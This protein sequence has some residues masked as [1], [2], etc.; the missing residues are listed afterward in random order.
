MD[1]GS[2]P[3]SLARAGACA[4]LAL[5]AF[6]ARPPA[7]QAPAVDPFAPG[8]R[9]QHASSAAAPWIPRDLAFAGSGELL[10]AAP[11]VAHPHLVLLSGAP[12]GGAAVLHADDSLASALGPLRVAAGLGAERVYALAQLPDP[13][14]AQRRT[15]IVAH[16]PLSASAAELAGSAAPF[17]PTWS[18][19]IGLS[20]N[21]SALLACDRAGERL[22]VA[23][24]QPTHTLVAW[25]DGAS[26]ATLAEHALPAGGLRRLALDAQATRAALVVGASLHV[27]RAD[28]TSELALA[29]GAATDALALSQNGDTLACGAGAALRRWARSQQGAWLEQAPLAGQAGE[30]CTRAALSADGQALALGWWH[31]ASGKRARFESWDLALGKRLHELSSGGPAS[32]VQDFPEAVAVSEDGQHFAF[33]AWGG[34]GAEPEAWLLRRGSSAPLLQ[35]DLGGSVQALALS[36]DGS[37]LAIAAKAAHANQFSVHGS[38]RLYDSGARDLQV[39]RAPRPGG[40]LELAARA[41]GALAAW[42]AFGWPGPAVPVPGL[43]GAL[44]LELA[45]PPC[46]LAAQPLGGG[47][48]AR[49]LPIPP[50]AA[51][52]G[53][54]LGVQA[55]F[56][57]PSGLALSSV[58][59][60]PAV[61]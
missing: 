43:Q 3:R 37:R 44:Q 16:E 13:D 24:A 11:A 27:L 59:A 29:L 36:A 9:W 47:E 26:G 32:S 51:W 35:A 48:F 30:L 10:V 5:G 31:A 54:E 34:L 55:A 41:P 39:L 15:W 8:L 52:I 50:S 12:S 4:A 33:G 61:L 22:V 1:N 42:F 17:A 6:A 58:L 25:L 2:V 28:G 57:T 56:L 19:S 23:L 21:G 60:R 14:P 18:R 20:G 45:L 49:S 40:A 7:Q 38:V 53:Q 46:L